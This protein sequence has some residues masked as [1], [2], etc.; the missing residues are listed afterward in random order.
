MGRDQGKVAGAEPP[1]Q[2]VE[3]PFD[4][5]RSDSTVRYH[6]EV[7]LAPSDIPATLLRMPG[8]ITAAGAPVDSVIE[9]SP[10]VDAH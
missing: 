10:V 6:P 5:V 8:F 9:G 3:W 7:P 1:Q 4:V 2:I